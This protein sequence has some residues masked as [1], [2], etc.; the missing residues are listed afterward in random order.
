VVSFK[1]DPAA[2]LSGR[3]DAELRQWF[4]DAPTDRTTHWT[5]WH[6]PENDS[7]DLALYRQAWQHLS[8][9]ADSAGNPRL[10][11]TLILMCW[12]L[13]RASGRDWRDYYPGDEAIDVMGFDCYN[14]GRTK[15]VYTD[16]ATVLGPV[17]TV[18][19]S[20]GKPWG[21]AEF[22]SLVVPEDGGEQGRAA[23]L[24]GMASYM[25]ENGA[26]FGTYFDSSV[27]GDFRLHDEPSRSAWRE[28]VQTY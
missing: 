3:H 17:R 2:I 10:R 9:L 23:W 25:K 14:T 7:V 15:G 28:V 22:G 8:A 4:A 13:A 5:Y 27:G 24:R 21:I 12:T 19:Q 11:S 16:P 6:E 18:A 20:V 1:N 26:A